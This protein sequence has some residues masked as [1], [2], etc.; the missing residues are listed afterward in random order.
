M[1]ISFHHIEKHY[2]ANEILNDVTLSVDEKEH[3][4]LI[5]RNGSGKTTLLKILMAKLPLMRA[6]CI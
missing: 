4:G 1:I 3:I 6:P 2:G 5:G